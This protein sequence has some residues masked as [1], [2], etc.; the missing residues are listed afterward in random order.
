LGKWLSN[1]ENPKKSNEFRLIRTQTQHKNPLHTHIKFLT[2]RVEKIVNLYGFKYVYKPRYIN[3]AFSVHCN[4]LA[5][6]LATGDWE[7]V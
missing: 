7:G 1:V 3:V 6:H 2:P 4:G 5:A